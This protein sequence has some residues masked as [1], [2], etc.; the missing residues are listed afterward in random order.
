MLPVRSSIPGLIEEFF[1]DDWFENFFG[2]VPVK[3]TSPKVNVIEEKDKYLIE[4][5]APGLDKED[6]RIDLHNDV[7]TISAEKKEEK[8]EKNKKYLRREF[9]YCSFKRSFSLPDTV[10][11]DKIDAKHRNGILKITIP[12]KEDAKEKEPKTIKIE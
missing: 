3:T 5:A 11:V 12:K 7:L 8:E 1:N 2:V 4:V 10:D 9:S 6:F